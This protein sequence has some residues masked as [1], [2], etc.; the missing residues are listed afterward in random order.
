MSQELVQEFAQLH[1]QFIEGLPSHAHQF[2]QVWSRLR[3]ENWEEE[4]VKDL[5]DFLQRLSTTSANH[6]LSDIS[7][8]AQYLA[9]YLSELLELRRR[10]GNNECNHLDV[11]I[12]AL[13]QLMLSAG[14]QTDP[15]PRARQTD[16]LGSQ[17]IYIIDQDQGHAALL[18]N[19]LTRAGF[20]T[21]GFVDVKT[22]LRHSSDAPDAILL[23][24]DQHP[25]G[26][27][28]A[29]QSLKEAYPVSTPLLLMSGRGE[30]HNRLH[31]LRAGCE[32][33]LLKPLNFE[34]L[35]EKL[36]Q[37]LHHTS[38]VARVL[39]IDP[40]TD[41]AEFA[42]EVL[43]YAGMD[44]MCIN[45]PLKGI[46][47]AA[48]FQPDLLLAEM[49]M[50]DI[51]GI[52]LVR[53]L[54]QDPDLVLLPVVFMTGDTDPG[55]HLRISAL[56]INDLLPKPVEAEQLTQIV[57]RT[58]ISTQALKDRVARVERQGLQTQ[59][60]N[61]SS[62][63]A[64]VE[65]E[66]RAKCP[67]DTQSAI[68]YFTPN[69]L[70]AIDHQLDRL[71]LNNLHEQFC[72]YLG[73]ILG[74]DEHW[75]NL[76]PLVACVLAGRR[77][78]DYHA[79]RSEQLV[80][81]LSRYAFDSSAKIVRIDFGRSVTS[82]D[83]H[84]EN[85]HQALLAAESSFV[86]TGENLDELLLATEDSFVD[87]ALGSTA[88]PLKLDLSQ[89]NMNRDLALSFQPII[90]VEA[91]KINH[92]SVLVRLRLESGELV[93]ASRFL[94]HFNENGTRPELDLWVLQQAI[95][96]LSTDTNIS[97]E[98]ILFIH[99]ARETLEHESFYERF[100]QLLQESGL[101]NANRLAFM[102]E[103]P[104]VED[105][106]QAALMVAQALLDMGCSICLARAGSTPSSLQIIQQLPMHYLRLTPELTR[107]PEDLDV[108]Q[109]I[110]R[111]AQDEDVQV[112]ATQVESSRNLSNLWMQGVRLFEGFFI[113]APEHELPS[114]KDLV[115]TKEYAEPS[116]F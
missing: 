51:S 46:E 93:N 112:I 81:H 34:L 95:A 21:V 86:L 92:F 68:Y 48:Q 107:P 71:Q 33:Y 98:A 10:P 106:R 100:G 8:Q 88:K 30:V 74:A 3:W 31:A 89:L 43:R 70:D 72:A 104:W 82:L 57:E 44:V 113:Q 97:A 76:S 22:C 65:E 35:L 85:A 109:E 45:N 90:S 96:V 116:R 111:A 84:L 42:A 108:L 87:D 91:E 54:R 38:R 40:D 114:Q 47:K 4:G 64:A 19:I 67:S 55:L 26:Q 62:F 83:H 13:K 20:K 25:E 101:P 1:Q 59:Q 50:N 60:V 11:K 2:G 63:F 110:I 105:N 103:E 6:K 56:G 5:Q 36:L 24:A 7:D 28:V 80:R 9:I 77:S 58:L 52:E 32:D 99:L 78:P 53:L 39:I 102:L 14:Q 94:H 66:I 23:D 75:L 115:T 41:A 12:E 29:I 16:K 17:R 61:T 27:L 73:Q 49:H 18:S 79:Q 37:S 15:A 69:R